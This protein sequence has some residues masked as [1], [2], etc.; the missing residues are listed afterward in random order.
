MRDCSEDIKNYHDD[1]IVID[2]P[3]RKKMRDHRNAN[4]DRLKRGLEAKKK[5]RP[6]ESIIQGSYAM[7]T[8]TQ[9]KENDYDIDDGAAFDADKV[10]KDSGA[11]MTPR[12]AREMVRDALEEGGGLR[13][14]PTTEKKCVRVEYAGGYHVDIPVYRRILNSRGEVIYEIASED[15]WCESNPRDIT[16]WFR[17][18]ETRTKAAD[19]DEP[20]LRRI[21][22]LLKAYSR[23]H[24]DKKS[25]SGLILTI[26]AEEVHRSHNSRE[27]RA[28][29]DL[30]SK[31]RSR[32]QSNRQVYNPANPVEILTKEND[33][34]K[35]DA[36]IE[37]IGES[38]EHLKVLDSPSCSMT[39]AR[40]AWDNA[41]KTDYFSALQQVD[42]D[43]AKGPYTPSVTEPEKKAYIRGP[44]TAA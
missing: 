43:A 2:G 20:Q 11:A 30:L 42:E 7:K 32:V 28:F 12:E 24:L 31:V 21:V 4:R 18:A 10:R 16:D 23:A 3:T 29:R 26:L 6:D 5:P 37:K 41:L 36:L 35:F 38:L 14:P 40:R 19:E 27:D 15:N 13:T 22:R 8:M 44:G 39:E 1:E 17:N 34:P 9:H 33:N 25:P